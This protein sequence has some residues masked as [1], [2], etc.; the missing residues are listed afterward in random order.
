M[1]APFAIDKGG[2]IVV[3]RI[4]LP[5]VV[6]TAPAYPQTAGNVSNG[7]ALGGFDQSEGTSIEPGGARRL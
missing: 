4:A 5:P 2:R 7:L 6:E 3:G 1:P